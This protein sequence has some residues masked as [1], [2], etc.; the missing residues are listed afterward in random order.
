MSI[1]CDYND[2]MNEFIALDDYGLEHFGATEQ[3][4]ISRAADA[5]R[6]HAK[7]A[8]AN[9]DEATAQYPFPLSTIKQLT[10][11]RDAA[12][13]A[14]AA[15]EQRIEA[16]EVI[17]ERAYQWSANYPLAGGMDTV[18]AQDIYNLC[19]TASQPPAGDERAAVDADIDAAKANGVKFNE[20]TP[21]RRATAEANQD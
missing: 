12:Q 8:A 1:Q 6:I 18:A 13:T 20:W 3:A 21:E 15:A 7:H 17:R 14:L 9:P 16:L 11:E 4:A 5:N 10:R 19:T 2:E